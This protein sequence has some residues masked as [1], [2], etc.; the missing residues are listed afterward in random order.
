MS[1]KG[2]FTALSGA[3]AQSQRLDTIAN[4]IA[5]ANTTAFKK[6]QQT[7]YEYLSAYE[8]PPD[9]VQVPRVPASIE[10]FYD[11]QGGDRGYVDSAGTFTDF[12]Q[13]QLR[14]TGSTLDMALEGRGLFEVLTPQGV[15]F[16]RNGQFKVDGNGSL[17]TKEGYLVLKDG[18]QDPAQRRIA[19]EGRNLTVSKN[20]EIYDAGNPVG[21]LSVVEV[22]NPDSLQKVGNSLYSLKP[23][24]TETPIPSVDSQ[25]NQGFLEL[26]NVNIVTEM[27]D[28]IAA[29]R[30]FE[31]A[32]KAMKAFDQMDDKLINEV[33]KT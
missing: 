13:G 26:S 1:S 16:T 18:T 3:M 22:S 28:M 33:P 9:V 19:V 31:T 17:V 29:S 7:F 11:M 6:D 27:T 20:G 23:N 24:F 5:N 12:T 21:R 10:S 30:T 4:N 25:V 14:P 32:Q 8:K 15:R 2:I